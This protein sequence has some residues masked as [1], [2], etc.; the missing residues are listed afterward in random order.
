MLAHLHFDHAGNLDAFPGVDVVVQ[1]AE[2]EA[3]QGGS[4]ADAAYAQV[5]YADV[6]PRLVD[7]E[8]DLL[9]DGSVILCPTYGH[10]PGHQ[11]VRVRLDDGRRVI[12]AGDAC[13]FPENLDTEAAPPYGWDRRREV[14][15]L[16]WLRDRRD[17]GDV[18]LTGHDPTAGTFCG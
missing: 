4:N 5:D 10:T 14:A 15:S 11:S 7:G 2:W 13:Y 16:R 18:V 9:G 17:V 8:H 3:A 6:S 1:R 12:I